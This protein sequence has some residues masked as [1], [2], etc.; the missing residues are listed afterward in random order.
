MSIKVSSN[1][2]LIETVIKLFNKE[3]YNTAL[4][5]SKNAIQ[6]C[7]LN[8]G[9]SINNIEKMMMMHDNH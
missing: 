3:E 4:A 9:S 5:H 2:E 7:F 8:I 6:S 1:N